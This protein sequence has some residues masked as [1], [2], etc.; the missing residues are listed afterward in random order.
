M[1]TAR[2]LLACKRPV[3]SRWTCHN[4]A[5][6]WHVLNA[7][8]STGHGWSR[9]HCIKRICLH[10]FNHPWVAHSPA[11]SPCDSHAGKAGCLPLTA[12][13]AR[14][15]PQVEGHVVAVDISQWAFNAV[16]QQ[17]LVAVYA[18]EET[19][20]LKVAFDRVCVHVHAPR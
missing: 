18:H 3:Q 6:S 11:C 9:T 14:A 1:R 2:A 8:P 12:E 19:R 4:G 13:A 7:L 5:E 20:V 10:K 16:S 15:W 17:A